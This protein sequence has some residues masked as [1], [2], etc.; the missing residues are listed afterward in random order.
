[1][2]RDTPGPP[3]SELQLALEQAVQDLV[4]RTGRPPDELASTLEALLRQGSFT[5]HDREGPPPIDRSIDQVVEDKERSIDRAKPCGQP[6]D[7]LADPLRW[8][9]DVARKLGDP[10]GVLCYR[11]LARRYPR[12]LLARALADALAVPEAK[13]RRSRAALFVALVGARGRSSR[14]DR[15]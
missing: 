2:T 12:D 4:D 10:A 14:R 8:A 15:P 5:V 1:M 9:E 3:E 6:V 13:I 7:R 11:S